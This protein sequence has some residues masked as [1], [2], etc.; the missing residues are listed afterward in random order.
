MS[1]F[2]RS[3]SGL[4]VAGGTDISRILLVDYDESQVSNHEHK[5]HPVLRTFGHD[6]F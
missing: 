1:N 5:E 3:S 6:V 2:G 4:D